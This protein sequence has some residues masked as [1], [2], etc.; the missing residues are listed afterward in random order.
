MLQYRHFELANGLQVYLHEDSTTPIAAF[1]LLYNVGSKDED[2]HKTGFAHL[3]EHLMFGGSKHIA[4]YDGA[5]Q[6]VGGENNAFTTPDLTNYYITL[7]AANLEAAF[8]LESDRM[9]SLS[10]DPEVLEVQRKVVIEEFKQRYLNQP[11]GDIWLKMR[12]LAY[13]VHPYQWAT[14]GKDISH[15]EKATMEDVKSF[16]YKFYTPNNA[17]LVVAGNVSLERVRY[18]AE[19]WFGDIPAGAPYKREL[20][21]EPAQ[22]QA[23]REI[24]KAEVPLK[25]IYKTYHMEGRNAETYYATD[26]LSDVLGRGKASRLYAQLVK[27]LKIFNDISAFVLGSVEPGLMVIGGKINQETSIE[28]AE[29]AIEKAIAPI[30]E[31]RVPQDELTKVKNQAESS[32]LMGSVEILNRAMDLAYFAML[33]KPEAINQ[34]S[35]M[36]Q[37]VEPQQ[38]F[39][40]AQRVLRA[41]NCSTLIYDNE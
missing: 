21:K 5:L 6:K 2:P 14:I 41:E 18:L 38:I 15:I 9:L 1:N 4:S 20:P 24:V 13:Q 31:A 3:F 37:A 29:E 23:R 11:Y 16:F 22:L 30:L 28:E 25:A 35:E 27:E 40:A 39:D 33:G 26:L 32:L 19:K 7:P 17:F 10:F 8:W 36:I 12:N 34:Q